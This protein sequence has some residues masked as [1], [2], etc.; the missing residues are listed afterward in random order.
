MIPGLYRMGTGAIRG[1]GRYWPPEPMYSLPGLGQ[2]SADL[3]AF[4]NAIAAG[5]QYLASGVTD[6]NILGEFTSAVQA[7]QAGA[8]AAV[9][10]LG[11]AI[12]TQT[13]GA[14]KSLTA[15]A[16]SVYANLSGVTST[17]SSQADAIS[18]SGY[19]HQMQALYTTAIALPA[20][21]PVT[22]PPTPAPPT[23]VVPTLAP[24]PTPSGSSALPWILGGVAV[25][26]AGVI[27]W[28]VL[29]KT[30]A[31]LARRTA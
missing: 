29:R 10:S 3:S 19:A 21:G 13:G 17:G 24:T 12:D 18:A 25:V 27:G 9:N 8:Q 14:S 11:P 30:P 22:A 31:G 15:Q 4:N 16:A 28:W 26:G 1:G 6:G 5:D 23:P 2:A 7:Y 20:P